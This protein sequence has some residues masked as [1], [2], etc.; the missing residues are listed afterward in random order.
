[1]SRASNLVGQMSDS[2]AVLYGWSG[3]RT[4]SSGR[5]FWRSSSSMRSQTGKRPWLESRGS[6]RR[7]RGSGRGP[8][9]SPTGGATPGGWTT[10]HS[11]CPNTYTRWALLLPERSGASLISP[12]SWEPTPSTRNFPLWEAVLVSRPGRRPCRAHHKDSPFGHR[13]DRRRRTA[14]APVRPRTPT[15]NGRAPNLAHFHRARPGQYRANT[16]AGGE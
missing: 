14:P 12:S 15:H 7:A 13:R 2:D 6:R 5:P 16:R 8:L 11:T 4:R 3:S 1:M 9:V 10:A